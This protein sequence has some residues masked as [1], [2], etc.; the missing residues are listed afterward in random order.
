MAILSLFNLF[1]TTN[2]Q[3][4]SSAA[5]TDPELANTMPGTG[6]A[7]IDISAD[8]GDSAPIALLPLPA[9][10][11]RRQE[12]RPPGSWPENEEVTWEAERDPAKMLKDLQ[13]RFRRD[14]KREVDPERAANLLNEVRRYGPYVGHDNRATS[15]DDLID[16]IKPEQV[17]DW[18]AAQGFNDEDVAAFRKG[19]RFAGMVNPFGTFMS[20]AVSYMV[21]PTISAATSPVI[22]A[23]LAV[24]Y[25][26]ISPT[27]NALQ[28]SGVVVL[29]ENIRERAGFSI[30]LT[31]NINDKN[32]VSDAAPQLTQKAEAFVAAGQDFRDAAKAFH[33]ETELDDQKYT[34]SILE[35]IA[36]APQAQLENLR[37][38]VKAFRS[39]ESEMHELQK[40][41]LVAE[42]SRAKQ[43]VG[44][45]WQIGPRGIRS[46]A[47]SLVG[48]GRGLTKDQLKAAIETSPDGLANTALRAAQFSGAA[49]VGIQAAISLVLFGAQSIAAGQDISNQHDYNN[50][51]NLMYGDILTEEGAKA[52]LNGP[53]T[54]D[55]IDEAKLRGMILTRD[56]AL[57]A[58]MKAILASKIKEFREKL[59]GET[60]SAGADAPAPAGTPPD[61]TAT[62]GNDDLSTP[63]TPPAESETTEDDDLSAR[64]TSP[65]G[66]AILAED[67]Q[68][69]SS[70]MRAGAHAIIA[71]S[72]QGMP[73]AE[74]ATA[75]DDDPALPGAYP[76]GMAIDEQAVLGAG[77]LQKTL[78]EMEADLKR[79]EAGNIEQLDPEGICAGLLAGNM[80][81]FFSKFLWE[82]IRAKY[83]KP[84][85]MP[86][87][88]MQRYGQSFHM[89]FLGSAT[90]SWIGQVAN[91]V[92]GGSSH[93]PVKQIAGLAVAGG[94]VGA[95]GAATQSEA[96]VIK[97]FKRSNEGGDNPVSGMSQLGQ[98]ML[99]LPNMINA[100]IAARGANQ[101]VIKALEETV[102]I[103]D[104]AAK[105][106]EALDRAR[107]LDQLR[108]QLSQDQEGPIHTRQS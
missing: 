41:L 107:R 27:L 94:V 108:A 62:A 29:C 90:A 72:P 9:T 67:G 5:G 99:A 64:G 48:L 49:G 88:I 38:A 106:D 44:N 74:A 92:V 57:V 24:A 76:T 81:S 6:D 71:H 20:N 56:Q 53:V 15:N 32:R 12:P 70:I 95:I 36:Q 35:K 103:L 83:K 14:A 54:A 102:D 52:S 105:C 18:Y 86:A 26:L 19:A 63:G 58:R 47:S 89:L 37:G 93:A 82:D 16:S 51:M 28:Q 46:T 80:N 68:E 79:L 66:I 11:R 8:A 61:E 25:S 1:R 59:P 42:S 50:R 39:T 23:G 2:K 84:G 3:A 33:G 43:Q 45:Q 69:S 77:E 22:G 60:A 100:G 7:V 91:A 73:P 34:S 104:L 97:N 30:K 17:R 4:S 40:D 75:G 31:K 98:G 65:A 13:E 85:E 55:H 87:Q 10:T 21:T 101:E 78:A 96:V